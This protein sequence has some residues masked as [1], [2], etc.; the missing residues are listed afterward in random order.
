MDKLC[1]SVKAIA[2]SIGAGSFVTRDQ[3][4]RGMLAMAQELGELGYKLPGAHSLKPKHVDALVTHWKGKGLSDQTIRNRLAW[5]RS[6]GEAINKP[7]LVPNLNEG[8]GLAERGRGTK[9]R[10][11]PL[12]QDDLARVP[13]ERVRLAL[14]LEAAF[15]LRR[16]EA[17]KMRPAVADLGNRLALRA[18]WCKGGRY[19]EVPL[20]HPKQRALLDE[21]KE[22]VGDG[23][24]INPGANY[25]KGVKR[26][27]RML[28]QGGIGNAHKYRHAYAQWRYKVLTGWAC[29][30]AGGPTCDRMTAAQERRDRSARMQI[31]HEMGHGRLDVTDTY[32]GRRWAANAKR[33]A[34]A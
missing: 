18:S 14:K 22:L 24:L 10:A 17:L 19:R 23:S 20:T 8:F 31:S 3:R 6:L 12:T 33:E 11:T 9:N 16:E 32:L 4:V 28:V 1:I 2:Y 29:P 5:V 30:L 26:Y 27:E 25:K 34:A 13:D 15:G 7:G 21:V